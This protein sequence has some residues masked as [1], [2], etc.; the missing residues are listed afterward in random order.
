M[1]QR[2]LEKLAGPQLVKKFPAFYGTRGFIAAF[3]SPL[4]I[5]ILSQSNPVH[6]VSTGQ[7]FFFS[8]CVDVKRNLGVFLFIGAEFET[9][10]RFFTRTESTLDSLFTGC[11]FFICWPLMQVVLV[12]MNETS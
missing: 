10:Y 2:L 5:L 11:T 12:G 8:L 7:E 4:P 6:T 9:K 1:K 3:T